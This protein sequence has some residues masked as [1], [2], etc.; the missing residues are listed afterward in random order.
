MHEKN[1]YFLLCIY[2]TAVITMYIVMSG[3]WHETTSMLPEQWSSVNSSLFRAS[4]ST[5]TVDVGEEYLSRSTANHMTVYTRIVSSFRKWWEERG[6]VWW[7]TLQRSQPSGVLV[8]MGLFRGTQWRPQLA[9]ELSLYQVV[10]MQTSCTLSR[11][12]KGHVGV[13]RLPM[14]NG[15]YWANKMAA[16]SAVKSTVHLQAALDMMQLRALPDLAAE[17]LGPLKDVTGWLQRRVV[18]E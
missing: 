12:W 9:S 7:V 5:V 16:V 3:D 14:R 17:A 18:T 15:F 11:G 6:N 4:Y 13:H 2:L 10:L 8:L 1:Y